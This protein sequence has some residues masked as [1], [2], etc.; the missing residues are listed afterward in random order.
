MYTQLHALYTYLIQWDLY[1][2][3]DVKVSLIYSGCH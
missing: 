2:F 3:S 1:G